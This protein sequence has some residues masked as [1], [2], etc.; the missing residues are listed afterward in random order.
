MKNLNISILE[1]NLTR[2]PNLKYLSDGTAVCEFTIAVNHF[3]K[4]DVSYF[5]CVAWRKLA[6]ICGEYLKKGKRVI[7]NG[8]LQQ[9]RWQ[10]KD[11][12]NNRSKIKIQCSEMEIIGGG[13]K[14]NHSGT[15]VTEIED[16]EIPE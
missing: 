9:K 10:D 5:D 2:D 13:N 7:V 3:K 14:G 8:Y 16:D 1:G 15:K 12:G 6:E 4:D 11:T